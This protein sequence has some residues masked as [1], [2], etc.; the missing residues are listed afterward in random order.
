MQLLDDQIAALEAID[1]PL[2]TS[3]DFDGFW[4]EAVRKVAA[5]DPRVSVHPIDY[6]LN[7]MTVHNLTYHGLDGTP[8][9]AW[10]LL[11]ERA[12]HERVPAMVRFHGGSG[13]RGRP[14]HHLHWVMAGCAVIAMDFRQQGGRTGSNTAMDAFGVDHWIAM[15]IEN[16][17]S[18][19]LYHA[20]TDGLLALRVAKGT[21]EIDPSRI[22]VGG[23]S[24]G[25]GTALAM[26]ALDPDIALCLADVP[27]FCWWEKR[28][29][30]QTAC[31]SKIADYIRRYPSALDIVL[32]T[33]SYFDV[34]NLVERVA[35]PV[36]GSCGLKDTSTPPECV[37]AA[38]N[39][40]RSGKT[41]RN[42]PFTGHMVEP[43]HTEE[44]LVWVRQ[45]FALD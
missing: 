13:S 45:R 6:P 21:P 2:T 10:L 26:A 32:S 9:A 37:Y 5:A 31:A 35:C 29:M 27:S 7:G 41:I 11:P 20:W 38:F 24:Q 23:S 30:T 8:I 42:Y 44:Q 28:I 22:A 3:P 12:R 43:W 1:P 16:H 39:K 15:N 4:A 36:L 14:F 34:M 17:E 25:G 40:I 33:L 19:Y 18:H